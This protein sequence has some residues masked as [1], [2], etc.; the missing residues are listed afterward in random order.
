MWA[1][2][3]WPWGQVPR[4]RWQVPLVGHV[5]EP[6][7]AKGAGVVASVSVSED[8]EHPLLPNHVARP[9]ILHKPPLLEERHLLLA[10]LSSRT[11]WASL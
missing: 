8:L 5:G 7:E 6:V 11:P 4:I 9:T 2:L 1:L 10:P 3:W